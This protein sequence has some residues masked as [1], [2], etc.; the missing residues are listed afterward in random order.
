MVQ[1][2]IYVGSFVYVVYVLIL[3]DAS[4]NAQ[5]PA[6]IWLHD[7]MVLDNCGQF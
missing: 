4:N 5:N 1:Q 7:P 6:S 2:N 3:S